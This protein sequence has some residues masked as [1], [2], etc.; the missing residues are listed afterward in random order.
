[1]KPIRNSIKAVIKRNDR[2]LLIKNVDRDGFWYTFP[3]GRQNAGEDMH[4]AVRRECFEETGFNVTVG[5]LRFIREYIGQ[6]HEFAVTDSGVHQVE[7]YFECLLD[8]PADPKNGHSKDTNQVD[9]EWVALSRLSEIR[10]YPKVF[11]QGL[12]GFDSIYLGD[13]N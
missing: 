13:I 2:V 10:L 12:D 3:G 11:Q 6:H 4:A 1:M 7:L 9:V 8:G 5:A